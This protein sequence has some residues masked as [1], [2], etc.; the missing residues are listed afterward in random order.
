MR[1]T[2]ELYAPAPRAGLSS[3]FP[4]PFL[5]MSII[6]SPSNPGWKPAGRTRGRQTYR[7]Y[8]THVQTVDGFIM[9]YFGGEEYPFC[10]P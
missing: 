7:F 6:I 1:V 3:P 2:R 9:D 5:R 10:A 4:P 8:E